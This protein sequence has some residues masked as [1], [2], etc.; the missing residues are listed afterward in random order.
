ML[1]TDSILKA[2]QHFADNAFAC[3]AE[4]VDGRVR[5][6]DLT[7]YVEDCEIR[8]IQHSLGK[9]DH[10]LTVRQYATWIQTGACHALL[11]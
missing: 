9:W 4:A 3:I 8:A 10:P 1:T 6:N 7:A 5:V 2:R 11:P